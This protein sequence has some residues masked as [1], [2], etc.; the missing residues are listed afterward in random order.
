MLVTD[1]PAPLRR[2]VA[3]ARLGDRIR[4][5]PRMDQQA[6]MQWMVWADLFAMPSWSE[7]FGLV[8]VEALACSSPV[9]MTSDCGLAPQIGLVT[10]DPADDQHGWVVEPRDTDAIARALHDA[11]G[12]R[13]RLAAMGRSGRGFVLERFTWRQNA[14]QLLGALRGDRAVDVVDARREEAACR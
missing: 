5:I 11:L 10:S 14:Q 9:L 13:Q 2:K 4:V 12:D 1:A 3:A 8:Y 6:L 7:A